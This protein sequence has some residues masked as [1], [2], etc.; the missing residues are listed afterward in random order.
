[1][2]KLQK[3]KNGFLMPPNQRNKCRFFKIKELVNWGLNIIQYLNK[4]QANNQLSSLLWI[5]EYEEDLQTWSEMIMVTEEIET[6]IKKE[7]SIQQFFEKYEK[8]EQREKQGKKLNKWLE[9]IKNYLLEEKAKIASE[10]LL[11]L[12][13]DVIESIFGKS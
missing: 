7:G 6:Q 10:K 12:S 3:T 13:S 5:K 2:R 11:Y 8:T 1:M 4:Q 9:K